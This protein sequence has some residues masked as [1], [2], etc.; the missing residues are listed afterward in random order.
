MPVVGPESL[1]EV[2]SALARGDVVAIPTETVYGLAA[3]ADDREAV[4]RMAMLKGRPSGQPFQLLVEPVE[5]VLPLLADAGALERVR[6]LWPGPLTAVVRARA[7]AGLAVVTEQ[8]TVGVRQPDDALARA[9]IEAAG[10]VIAATSANLSGE[11][12][13]TTAR[14][15]V[16]RFGGELLVLDGGERGGLS[17]STVVDL[18]RDPPVLLRAGPITAGEL[19][20]RGP[21]PPSA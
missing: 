16:R 12:P 18:T 17:P 8:G 5:A 13:A 2:A 6:A 20:I 14:D 15:V 9:V 21:S 7:G 11:D 19:G 1:G 4:G 10:G 3:R